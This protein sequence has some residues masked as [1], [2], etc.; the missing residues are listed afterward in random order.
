MSLIGDERVINLQCTK[1]YVF[2]DSMFCF[3]KFLEKPQSNESWEDR[4]EWFK[5]SPAYR[6]FDRIDGEPTGLRVEYFPSG[7][8]TLQLSEEVKCLLLR[9]GET[10]ENLTSRIFYVDVQGHFLWIKRQ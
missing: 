4:L 5:S 2:L 6:N 9:L 7:F 10:P 3:G 1:V 8:N